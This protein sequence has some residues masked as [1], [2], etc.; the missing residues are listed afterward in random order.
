MSESTGCGSNTDQ[1]T[2][3]SEDTKEFSEDM[4]EF[5]ED[6]EATHP[7]PHT[8]SSIDDDQFAANID[9]RWDWSVYL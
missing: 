2:K 7:L 9:L 6:E 1:I 3:E 5:S 4:K 8:S